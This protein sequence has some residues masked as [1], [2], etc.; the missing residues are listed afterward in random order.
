[1]ETLSESSGEQ[2]FVPI[3]R[4]QSRLLAIAVANDKL[5]PQLE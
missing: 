1:M 5:D 2:S 3:G 4:D